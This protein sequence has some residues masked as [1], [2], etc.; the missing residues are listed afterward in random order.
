VTFG[1]WIQKQRHMLELTL[2]SLMRRKGKY[3]ALI[4]VY[5]SI[6][7]LLASVMFFTHALK[8][9]AETVLSA[10]PD[11]VVQK[12][13]AGRHDLIPSSYAEKIREIRGVTSVRAALW[14]Y[15]Y[16]PVFGANYTLMVPEDFALSRGEI[17]IGPGVAKATGSEVDYIL[18]FWTSKGQLT[19]FT[20]KEL[21]ATESELASADLI[22]MSEEDF[23]EL[24]EIPNHLATN[25]TLRVR[26]PRELPVIAS[27]ITK[28]LPD[29]RPILKTELMRTYDTVFSWRSGVV[30]AVLIGSVLA[31][32]IFSWDKASGLSA[33]ERREI[34]ILKAIGWETS[35]VIQMKF[36]EGAVVSVTS[37]LVGV[38][39]AYAHVFLTSSVLFEPVL[40]GWAVIYPDFRLVPFLDGY[41]IAV[42]FFLTVVPYTVSTI[43]PSWRAATVDPDAVMRA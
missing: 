17:A 12:L 24:F 39:A 18:P 22:L 26:N 40:K 1:Q 31:F 4:V 2:S 25:L 35:D 32:V 43:V 34:G 16:D 23:R 14:G 9:E 20:V 13:V 29:T 27:K 36:W 3:V 15:Y 38:L 42:L 37:F 21:L 8:H 30:V 33:E 10:A 5:T 28:M 41:Q 11:I 6:V 19:S 7:F